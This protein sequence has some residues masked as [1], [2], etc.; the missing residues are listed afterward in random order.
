MK[1]GMIMQ[2]SSQIVV[3]QRFLFNLLCLRNFPKIFTFLSICPAVWWSEQRRQKDEMIFANK[4]LIF[5]ILYNPCRHD[6]VTLET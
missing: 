2:K 5:N 1:G 6:F 3:E 4:K